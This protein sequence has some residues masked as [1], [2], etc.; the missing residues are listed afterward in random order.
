MPY[1]ENT[2]A[3]INESF[4]TSQPKITANFQSIKTVVEQDHED[5]NG[6]NEGKHKKTTFT[7]TTV[8]ALTTPVATGG[9]EVMLYNMGNALFFRPQN[10]PAGN[11]DED[12]DFTTKTYAAGQGST[13]LPSGLIMKWGTIN[14]ASAAPSVAVA[15]T[16]A[17]PTSTYY[18][19]CIPSADHTAGVARYVLTVDNVAAAGFNIRRNAADTGTGYDVYWFAIG[20]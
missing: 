20:V 4:S 8:V 13:T 6:A 15:F 12:I 5:F 19:S 9:T 3:N 2:P 17:F 10:R 11:I 1:N 14:L 16:A 18:A 7:D